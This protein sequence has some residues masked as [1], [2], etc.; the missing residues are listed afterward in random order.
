MIT[1]K[2]S[3]IEYPLN[4]SL[5]INKLLIPDINYSEE[6]IGNEVIRTANYMVEKKKSV[7]NSIINDCPNE[8]K[9]I[10]VKLEK[11]YDNLILDKKEEGEDEEET[12]EKLIKNVM[13]DNNNIANKIMSIEKDIFKIKSLLPGD[14]V[15]YN[16][17]REDVEFIVEINKMLEVFVD[18]ENKKYNL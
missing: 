10:K 17:K 1:N 8:E 5:D 4:I 6:R 9:I 18:E 2:D 7:F 11:N 12:L 15:N 3:I 14:N 16:I 13:N